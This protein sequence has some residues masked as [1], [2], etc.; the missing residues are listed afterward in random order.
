MGG[1][2]MNGSSRL[3]ISRRC[4]CCEPR[5]GAD[6]SRRGF[7]WSGAAALGAVATGA[8]GRA[9]A[10]R[11][12]P[13]RIDVHHHLAPPRWIADVV[14]GRNTGQRPLADWTPARSIEDMDKGRVAT[15]ITSISEPSVW[16]G[17]NEAARR[18]ARECNEYAAKLVADHPG[19]FGMFAILPLPDVDGALREAEYAFDTLEA[20][21]ICLMTSYQSKYL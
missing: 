18:L 17:D 3:G 5:M 10:E 2:G 16:F 8:G 11:A 6:I 20:D 7:L 21:G 9:L 19:R 15:S 13:R 4:S 1:I 12:D 14:L